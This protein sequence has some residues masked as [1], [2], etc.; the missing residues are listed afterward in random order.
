ML[1]WNNLS[2]FCPLKFPASFY[3]AYSCRSDVVGFEAVG[4]IDVELQTVTVWA[5]TKEDLPPAELAMRS[6]LLVTSSR[7]VK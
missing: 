3:V 7:Q 5:K 1:S 6:N 4:L 2:K